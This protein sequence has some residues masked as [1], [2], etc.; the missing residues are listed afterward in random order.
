MA[1]RKCRPTKQTNIGLGVERVPGVAMN[2]GGVSFYQASAVLRSNID[3]TCKKVS[4]TQ[5]RCGV[6]SR[7]MRYGVSGT[8]SGSRSG[9]P[10]GAVG[11][12]VLQIRRRCNSQEDSGESW[13]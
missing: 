12:T 9:I 2:G 11:I 1:A 7:S 4:G 3:D 13:G 5:Q 10:I 8:C 6:R